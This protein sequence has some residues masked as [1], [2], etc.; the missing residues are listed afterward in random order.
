V[1]IVVGEQAHLGE[2]LL[3]LDRLAAARVEHV[4]VAAAR[5]GQVATALDL[6]PP[7]RDRAAPL[8]PAARPAAG[9]ILALDPEHRPRREG[10]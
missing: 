10:R 8:H 9:G 3:G 4:R 6:A 1:G 5:A 7:V 2:R